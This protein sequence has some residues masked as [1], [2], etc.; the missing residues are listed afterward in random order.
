[1][2][3]NR[4]TQCLQASEPDLALYTDVISLA[5]HA[6]PRGGLR[7]LT[8][9]VGRRRDEH[10]QL[11]RSGQP[12][13]AAVDVADGMNQLLAYFSLALFA[14]VPPVV[15]FTRYRVGSRLPWWVVRA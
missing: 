5:S 13:A 8:R 4:P 2:F 9:H 11:P 1:L 14:A 12:R 10:P 3:R 7:Q 15:F 6:A